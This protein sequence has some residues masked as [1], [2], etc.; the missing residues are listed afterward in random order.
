[1]MPASKF[2]ELAGILRADAIN[3]VYLYMSGEPTYHPDFYALL[4]V[5]NAHKITANVATKLPVLLDPAKIPNGVILDLTV[6]TIW[7]DRQTKIAPGLK[8][9][10]VLENLR[11]LSGRAGVTGT[12]VVN[13]HN[14]DHLPAISN[15]F[16]K[17]KIPWRAKAMGYYMGSKLTP[18]A[19]R[20]IVDLLPT[21]L[22]WRQ[23]ITVNNGRLIS[24]AR[25]CPF[26]DPAISVTG[27][28]T[29]CCHDMIFE[30]ASGNVFEAGSLRKVVQ[31]AKYQAM[32]HKGNQMAITICKGCN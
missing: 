23:R 24:L 20:Q 16:K 7:Q 12:T 5:L 13:I 2:V 10:T 21:N 27:E 1:M 26:H 31:S 4:E 17:L 14:E 25:S 19:E 9:E 8:T 18:E 6:D 29:V 11:R 22:K 32:R 3:Y 28:V 30:A 15:H